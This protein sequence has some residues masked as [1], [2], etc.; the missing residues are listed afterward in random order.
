MWELD[1]CQLV[2]GEGEKLIL[3]SGPESLVGHHR[4]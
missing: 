1:A 2:A 3:T 4:N